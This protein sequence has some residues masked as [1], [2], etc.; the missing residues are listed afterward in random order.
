MKFW[1][2]L[3]IIVLGLNTSYVFGGDAKKCEE[4][5][6]DSQEV[7][8]DLA[9]LRVDGEQATTGIMKKLLFSLFNRK[10]AAAKK[11]QVDVSDLPE[12]VDEIR[13]DGAQDRAKKERRKRRI[14][15][16]EAPLEPKQ[17]ARGQEIPGHQ[18]PITDVVLSP[19]ANLLA[20]FSNDAHIII[21][22]ADTGVRVQ[23]LVYPGPK[24]A[25][26]RSVTFHPDGRTVMSSQHGS[27]DLTLWDVQ[28]GRVTEVLPGESYMDQLR[29]VSFDK[30]GKVFAASSMGQVIIKDAKTRKTLVTFG[31]KH[32]SKQ[33][34]SLRYGANS[35]YL[36]WTSYDDTATIVRFKDDKNIVLTGHD[37]PVMSG[38]LNRE[39]T[40]AVTGDSGGLVIVWDAKTGKELHR[41]QV[42][43]GQ[44][45]FVSFSPDGAYFVT[46]SDDKVI[47]WY[48]SNGEK[49]KDL[50][51]FQKMR[52]TQYKSVSFSQSGH[53][54]YAG[55]SWGNLAYWEEQ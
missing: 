9:R 53:R 2:L 36:M 6:S 45:A 16:R 50:P 38:D 20:T 31:E 21:R 55:D 19:V 48:S 23:E 26:I 28:T 39:G 33:V 5:F 29:P 46:A 35:D 1:T 15:E 18:S 41:L 24:T 3:L 4:L 14:F 13:K 37:R 7:V 30:T 10:L 25:Y 51:A 47:L 44:D 12:I 54:I 22:N 52:P 32:Q 49:Y 34:A 42:S 17:W 43:V 40:L 8:E 11:A 27:P